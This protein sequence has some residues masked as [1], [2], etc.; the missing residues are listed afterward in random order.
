MDGSPTTTEQDWTER[1][2]WSSMQWWLN[3]APTYLPFAVA[4]A[5]VLALLVGLWSRLRRFSTGG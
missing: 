4:V 1:L 2:D 5:S 3:E